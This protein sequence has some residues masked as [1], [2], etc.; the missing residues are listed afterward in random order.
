MIKVVYLDMDGVITN[1]VKGVYDA[2]NKPYILPPQ[3]KY[4]FWKYW[5]LPATTKQVD[6][7]CNK[8]FWNNLEWMYDGED[9]L[10]EIIKYFKPEKTYLLTHPMPNV[11]SATGKWMWVKGNMPEYYSRTIITQAPKTLLAK[12]E[13]LLID[14]KDENVEEFIDAG[15]D[16]ILVPRPWN[17]LHKDKDCAR[18]IVASELLKRTNGCKLR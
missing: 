1:F 15:G 14:D 13:T 9:I 18:F 7:I 11:E 17:K 16:A 5:E 3:L 2:F 8:E 12:P 4:D 6:L 10:K